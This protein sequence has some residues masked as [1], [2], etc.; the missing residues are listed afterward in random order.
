MAVPPLYRIELGRGQEPLWAYD[1]AEMQ[2][3]LQDLS[4]S[5]AAARQPAAAAAAAGDA[6]AKG[7]RGS[8]RRG[9]T[10]AGDGSEADGDTGAAAAAVAAGAGGGGGG[11]GGGLSLPAGVSVTRF[12]GLGEMMP[13]QLWST[14]L[15]PETRWGGDMYHCFKACRWCLSQIHLLKKHVVNGLCYPAVYVD[16]QFAAS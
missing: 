2:R 13:E 16:Y 12:K 11:A 14:T 8:S 15:N 6:G 5:R 1:D 3:V 4:R 9:T 10:S 7:R